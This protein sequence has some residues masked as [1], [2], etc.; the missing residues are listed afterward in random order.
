RPFGPSVTL[1]ALARMSTP[2][3][4]RSRASVLNFTSLA[5]MSLSSSVGGTPASAGDGGS[6]LFALG[7]ALDDAHEI[8]FLHDHQLLAV[9]LDLGAGPFAEQHAVAGLDAQRPDLAILAG[10]ART[11]GDDLALHRL[12]LGGVRDDDPAGRLLLLRHA[13][14]QDTIMQWLKTHRCSP[15]LMV[16]AIHGARRPPA[17]RAPTA[18]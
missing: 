11:D 17:S 9:H 12:L 10:G 1:T 6:D 16:M 2:R 3:S 14:D 15:L 5:A 13:A 18:R 8:R 4:I 7:G